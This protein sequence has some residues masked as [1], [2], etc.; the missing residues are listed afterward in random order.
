MFWSG[1]LN[2]FLVTFAAVALVAA[3]WNVYVVLNDDG[4]ISGRVVDR[5]G[6][7]VEGAKVTLS[8]RSLLVARPRGQTVT[9][10]KGQFAF[11]GHRLHRLYLEVSKQGTGRVGQREYRL[12]FKGQNLELEE[13]L[14]LGAEGAT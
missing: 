13:P 10:A 4:M 1:L 14:Q 3:A 9:D 8:E 2:R 11:T 12:Y 7:P 6:N 5:A